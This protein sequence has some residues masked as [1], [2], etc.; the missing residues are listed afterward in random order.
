GYHYLE[1][2]GVHRGPRKARKGTIDGRIKRRSRM[3]KN[4]NQDLLDMSI[5]EAKAR[6][7]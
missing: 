5:A 6:M 3:E 1:S 7:R 2:Q 4:D